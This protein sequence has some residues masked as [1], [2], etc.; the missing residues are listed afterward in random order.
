MPDP[1]PIP[2]A[3]AKKIKKAL[4]GPLLAPIVTGEGPATTEAVPATRAPLGTI[5]D[6]RAKIDAA[7]QDG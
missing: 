6:V 2:K 3:V 4:T 5:Q 7:I 1:K